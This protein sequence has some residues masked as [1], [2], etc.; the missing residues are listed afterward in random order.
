MSWFYDLQWDLLRYLLTSW[1]TVREIGRLDSATCHRGDR[2]RFFRVVK[3]RQFVALQHRKLVERPQERLDLKRDATMWLF[4]RCIGV[5]QLLVTT[6]FEE[7]SERKF[8]YLKRHGKKV[9]EVIFTYHTITED[10]KGR[11]AVLDQIR[12]RCPKVLLL[13]WIPGIEVEACTRFAEKWKGLTHVNICYFI[14]G[15]ALLVIGRECKTLTHL[16]ASCRDGAPAWMAF[17]EHC[18]CHLQSLTSGD[19]FYDDFCIILARRCHQLRKLSIGDPDSYGE[20]TDEA[21]F[22]L[23]DSCQLLES[24]TLTPNFGITD[25]GIVALATKLKL[26][27][28]SIADGDT[29][30]VA[31]T[32][33]E[34]ENTPRL[35]DRSLQ[36]VC[37]HG[38][39]LREL[40]VI[41]CFSMTDGGLAVMVTGCPQLEV[42]S[43][44]RSN[45]NR[46]AL[47]AVISSC[48]L[49][50]EFMC[51]SDSFQVP[52]EAVRALARRC[53]LLEEVSLNGMELGDAGTRALVSGCPTLYN[54]CI[55]GYDVIRQGRLFHGAHMRFWG[56]I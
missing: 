19:V 17:L 21:L 25:A 53:P 12:A 38:R 14:T 4:K 22:T 32:A 47:D 36:A 43:V 39:Y 51:I 27:E 55:E 42:L 2:A 44:I 6:A 26:K 13:D 35:T 7:F 3:A 20:L 8:R 50:R 28:L 9:R 52:L 33:E 31:S 40:H 29:I 41:D 10:P 46:S 37:T 54:F 11:D 49:L 30:T 18:S 45:W 56:T 23:A 15:E 24:V 48:P 5:S 1:V 16:Q 34:A